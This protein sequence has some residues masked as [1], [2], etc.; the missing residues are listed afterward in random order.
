[1]NRDPALVDH[2]PHPAVL[3]ALRPTATPLVPVDAS[4]A[5]VQRLGPVPRSSVSNTVLAAL[6]VVAALWWGQRFLIPVVAGLM[7]AMLVAPAVVVFE[8]VL[9]SRMIATLLAL[10][11]VI[12]VVGGGFWAFGGQIVRMADRS[13]EMI[14][15]MADRLAKTRPDADSVL[16]RGRDALAQLDRAAQSVATG[17]SPRTQRA[18]RGQQPADTP[19]LTEGATVLVRDTAK[20]GSHVLLKFATDISVVLFIA[21]FVLCGGERLTARFL[22]LWGHSRRGRC[23]AE[24]ALRETAHQIRMYAGTLLVTNTVIGTA[25]WLAFWAASLPDAAMWGVTAAVLHMVPYLGMAILVVAG[26][27]ETFLVHGTFTAAFAMAGFLVLLSTLVGTA[28]T[29]WLQGRAAKMN[30]AAV[31]VGLV[32]WGALWGVWGLFLGPALIVVLKVIARNSR[33]A[34]RMSRLMQG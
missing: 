6:A 29:A 31:F 12:A 14:Q 5:S 13:P 34:H 2:P 33:T 32:F 3:S 17:T 23:R 15:L 24:R 11:L 7:L 30:A 27:A 16:K 1:M 9:R 28:M 20:S 25:V 21:F 18:L 4:L 10:S 19:T 22:D 8:R 26:S